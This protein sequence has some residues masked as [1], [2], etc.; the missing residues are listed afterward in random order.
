[1]ATSSLV[2]IVIPAFN[3]GHLI[4]QTLDSVWAQ[5]A[6]NWE[7]LVVDDGSTDE[8][9]RIVSDF[10]HRD[11]RFRYLWQRNT[12]LSAA[13]NTGLRRAKGAYLQLLDAD[14]LIEAK[15][16]EYQAAHLDAHPEA[17]I[18]YG[19]A[20]YFPTDDGSRLRY[21]PTD[22]DRAWMPE[23]SGSG[24]IMVSALLHANI[25]PV[26]SALLRREVV[27]RVGYFDERLQALEDW[28]YWI[29]CALA[30]VEFHF[31]DR[32]GTR[33][34]VRLHA[35]S[36]STDSLR[37]RTALVRH[38]RATIRLA[39][40]PATRALLR[41]RLAAARGALSVT[42][43]NRGMIIRGGLARVFLALSEGQY[44]G[45]AKAILAILLA[46]IISRARFEAW[47]DSASDGPR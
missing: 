20:R 26:H 17:G 29:R 21:S 6:P 35:D 19:P 43:I 42:Q 37:M 39:P 24:A 30:G 33:A 45:A 47:T 40:D 32:E 44:A 9:A 13:R 4:A 34:L 18:V 15:K 38:N 14:D 22:P 12:G 28:E 41:Q 11:S 3:Y 46:P 1:M 5:S 31:L 23:V 16:L 27:D 10:A 2:T 25:M 7:C 8:T 36:M